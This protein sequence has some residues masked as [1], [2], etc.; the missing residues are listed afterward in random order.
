MMILAAIVVAW[1]LFTGVAFDPQLLGARGKISDFEAELAVPEK[2]AAM[3]PLVRSATQCVVRAVLANPRLPQTLKPS[4]MNE[5]IVD[6]MTP[7]AGV[8]R[9]MID[10]HDRL[11]GHGSG[12]AFFMGPYLDVLPATVNRSVGESEATKTT[13]SPLP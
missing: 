6:S 7:C 3:R 11:F 4:D 10:A 13:T 2:E 12:E 1:P 5:L 8:I 9:I